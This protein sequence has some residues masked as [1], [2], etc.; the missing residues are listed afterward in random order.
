MIS[1]QYYC[2]LKNVD[3]N[4]DQKKN[5]KAKQIKPKVMSYLCHKEPKQAVL[6]CKILAK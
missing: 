5:K 6:R 1:F 4:N 3:I 2:L